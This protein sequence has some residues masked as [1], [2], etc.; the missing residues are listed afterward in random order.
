MIFEV[1]ASRRLGVCVFF[2]QDRQDFTG[3]TIKIVS[4]RSCKSCQRTG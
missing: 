1:M 4:C 3:V 2:R